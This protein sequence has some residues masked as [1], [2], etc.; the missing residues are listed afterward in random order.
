MSLRS[1]AAG[2]AIPV[3]RIDLSLPPHERYKALALKYKK[4]VA[5]ITPLFNELLAD[6]GIPD[7]K[8]E[9]INTL[10][11]WSLRRVRSREETEELRGISEVTGVEM[12]LLVALN[13][14]L[15]LLMGCTSSVLD[16]IRSNE[17]PDRVLASSIT[18]VGF[19]G[20]LTGVRPHLMPSLASLEHDLPSRRTTAAYL[21]FSDGVHALV[22][23]KD[24]NT[25][26]ARHD[27]DGFVVATNHDFA[28]PAFDKEPI[29]G[30]ASAVGPSRTCALDDFMDDSEERAACVGDKWRRHRTAGENG[31]T[32]R[33]AAAWT[34]DWP[35]ANETT[36]YACVLDP[37][38]GQ[39][40]WARV[41]VR[42][43]RE[44]H[45]RL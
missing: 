9:T 35:T 38:E 44:P 6:L 26:I 1:T 27:V 11:R 22:L 10:A 28:S 8:H 34:S 30:A 32:R 5:T 13:V 4:Q 2:R 43:L 15:D 17:D 39:V 40:E 18:Y 45:H 24:Y 7:A 36:H 23:E 3:H 42:P 29:P 16:Y 20:V 37:D 12:Y 21:T 31:I 19:V 41:Y 33:L 14:V 25:A